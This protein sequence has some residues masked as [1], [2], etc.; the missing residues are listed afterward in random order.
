MSEEKFSK[1]GEEKDVSVG[2]WVSEK[3]M[4]L[5]EKFRK[6]NVFGGNFLLSLCPL[7]NL[8]VK[9]TEKKNE[10]FQSVFRVGV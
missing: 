9:V 7:V 6:K 8:Q 5:K 3:K 1:C 10:N 4:K 2:F